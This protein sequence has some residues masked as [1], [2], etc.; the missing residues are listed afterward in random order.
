MNVMDLKH[1]QPF[2]DALG[3]DA[4]DMSRAQINAKAASAYAAGCLLT[5]GNML[6]SQY[7]LIHNAR[8]WKHIAVIKGHRNSRDLLCVN[9]DVVI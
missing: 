4:L 9:V 6:E 8:T 5:R 2:A 1:Q 7:S 3:E